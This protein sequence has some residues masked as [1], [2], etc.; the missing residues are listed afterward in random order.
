MK[1]HSKAVM[2]EADEAMAGAVDLLQ[3]QVVPFG[4]PVRGSRSMV[5]E[6]F[7]LS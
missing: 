6:D 7:R 5:V 4:Q 2:I 1:Q 3:A